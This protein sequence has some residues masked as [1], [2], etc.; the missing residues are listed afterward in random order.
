MALQEYSLPGNTKVTFENSDTSGYALGGSSDFGGNVSSLVTSGA[1]AGVTGNVA[2]VIN[3]A[4]S[5]SGTTFMT[6]SNSEFINAQSEHVSMRV[7]MPDSASHV[8][9]LKLEDKS[10][11]DKNIE[12]DVTTTASGWQTLDF[13][14]AGANHAIDFNKA[15]VFFD[16]GGST[17][18]DGVYYFDNVAYNVKP[19]QVNGTVT[20]ESSD[21]SGYTLGDSRDFGGNVSSLMTSGVPAGA[22]GNVAKV[23]NGGEGWSGT[24]FLTL[25][26]GEL[27]S[28]GNEHIS[29]KV[30]MPDNPGNDQ[31]K[32]KLKL[33][34]KSDT[35]KFKEVDVTTVTSGW[36]TLDFSFAGADHT[37]DYNKASVFFDFM[38]ANHAGS[39]Y[40]F[41]DVKFGTSYVS[42]VAVL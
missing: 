32:V 15:S 35:S 27:I 16:F 42:P 41:D 26:S 25:P 11:G 38:G 3:G 1:P 21:V 8:V 6:L 28:A 39:T 34:D 20:F 14:F 31:R 22:T 33:E 5:W 17:H 9:K 12:K 29:M 4:E 24:T 10:N 30:Y 40:Y 13:N 36:Q 7:Y 2:K 23:I 19:L 18:P 37:V